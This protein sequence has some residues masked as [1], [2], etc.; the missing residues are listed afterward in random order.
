MVDMVVHRHELRATLSTAAAHADEA[1]RTGDKAGNRAGTAAGARSQAPAEASEALIIM[2]V[3]DAILM[4]LLELHPKI[5]D[6]SLDR[7]WRLLDSAG[8]SASVAAAGRAYCRHQRQGIHAGHMR[9]PSSRRPALSAH[10][11][12]SPHLVKFH[13]RI[14]L[15][16][17]GRRQLIP[18]QMLVDL[19]EEC[20]QAN[21]RRADH[22]LR[23]YHGCRHAGF[24]LAHRQ[25]MCC[26]KWGL[27]A[28]WMPPTSLPTRRSA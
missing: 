19:L 25:T 13:E 23:D 10:A 28:G 15:G 26:W 21:R 9:A 27:A 16:A 4:R 8:Q 7:M 24:L 11:Y 20:E 12:T 18:E 5:I 17:P 3:S 6:L 22:V 1:A 14:R 2:A